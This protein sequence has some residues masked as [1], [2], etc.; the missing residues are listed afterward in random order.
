MAY[1]NVSLLSSAPLTAF[2]LDVILYVYFSKVALALELPPPPPPPPPAGTA[3]TKALPVYI[4]NFWFKLS[5]KK[6]PC[7]GVP[8]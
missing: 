6:L 1:D 3:S 7:T 4:F 2:V 5:K 8:L